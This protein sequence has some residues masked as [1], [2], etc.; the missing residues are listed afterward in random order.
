MKSMPL[1][2]A[3]FL[4]VVTTHLSRSYA[5]GGTSSQP[6][7]FRDW[8]SVIVSGSILLIIFAFFLFRGR[9][10]PEND[11]RAKEAHAKLQE[12]LPALQQ[13][14]DD[15]ERRAK[16]IKDDHNRHLAR[17]RL[18][19]ARGTHWTLQNMRINNPS[20]CLLM[21]PMLQDVLS[22]CDYVMQMP[23]EASEEAP[24]TL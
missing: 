9:G 6:E 7:G 13:R 19:R 5:Q 11:E 2:C 14:L 10:R 4:I 1:R 23:I 8:T 22:D 24:D 16:E 20:D 21:W 12:H 15:A 3:A 18:K 17:H